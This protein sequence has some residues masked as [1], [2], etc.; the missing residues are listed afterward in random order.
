ME[1]FIYESQAF[2]AYLTAITPE[3]TYLTLMAMRQKEGK[4]LRSYVDSYNKACSSSL[5]KK[6]AMTYDE[7]L[8]QCRKYGRERKKKRVHQDGKDQEAGR[9]IEGKISRANDCSTQMAEVLQAIEYDR[10]YGHT[11]EECRHLTDEIERLIRAGHLKE[12]VY[13]DKE[14]RQCRED[15]YRTDREDEEDDMEEYERQGARKYREHNVMVKR[16]GQSWYKN[17]EQRHTQALITRL[18]WAMRKVGWKL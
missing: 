1:L 3:K 2:T 13:K 16:A 5:A 17:G 14:K 8:R 11:T 4:S 7:V 15:T 9:K 12:F 10:D 18:N 6:G